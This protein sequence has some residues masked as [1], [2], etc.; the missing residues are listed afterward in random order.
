MQETYLPDFI[1]HDSFTFVER[2][3]MMEGRIEE[4]K[5]AEQDA[6]DEMPISVKRSEALILPLESEENEGRDRDTG[7][8][9]QREREEILEQMRTTRVGFS[10]DKRRINEDIMKRVCQSDIV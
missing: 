2:L 7:D 5:K 6:D 8:Y 10:L 3:A 9:L 1:D 4:L